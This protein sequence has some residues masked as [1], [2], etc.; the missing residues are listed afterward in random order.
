HGLYRIEQFW[1]NGTEAG[2][3]TKEII[4]Y[5]PTT[6]IEEQS[7][8]N[9]FTESTV[10]ISVDFDDSYTPQGLDGIFANVVY[11]FDGGANI[12]L[13]DQ[14]GGTW[15]A[16]ISTT[17]I[18]PGRYTIIVYAEGYALENQSTTIDVSLI[19]DTEALTVVWSNTNDISYVEST[20]LSVA[21][22]RLGGVPVTG[23]DVNVTI[24]TT[25]WV[26][27]WDSGSGTYKRIFYGDDVDPGFGSHNL[28]IL[29]GR[30]GYEPQ[31]DSTVTLDISEESTTLGIAWSGSTSIT[32]V[33][34]VTL[35]VNYQMS[36]TT[37][38]PSATVEVT[39]DSNIFVMNW[40]DT[41]KRYWYQFNGNDLLPG[42][43]VHSL[44]IE[45]N[46]FGYQYQSDLLQTLTI[47]EE[48]TTLVLS[49]SNGNSITYV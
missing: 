25:T 17:G 3:R 20:E 24:G 15:T 22:N 19:H 7:Q 13:V 40:N 2:Y 10:D 44:T 26:L 31:S 16:S 36:N 23:A 4:L 39:I 41:S 12:S 5:Y 1:S 11:S 6:L 49:W 45:A 32:Y 35:Y 27:N 48:P 8:I 34:S 30:S 42:I 29:A 28:T 21:Y 33:E 37:A 38:I 46:K 9:G 47:T 14:S 43:G 18:S